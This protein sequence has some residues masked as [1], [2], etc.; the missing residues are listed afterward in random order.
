MAAVACGATIVHGD[1]PKIETYKRLFSE[2]TIEDLDEAYARQSA[3]NYMECVSK[4]SLPKGI[5][6]VPEKVILEERDICLAGE[7]K[8]TKTCELRINVSN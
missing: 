3:H 8:L 4:R 6:G 1:R 7:A 2:C 5:W